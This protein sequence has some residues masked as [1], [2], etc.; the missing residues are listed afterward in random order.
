MTAFEIRAGDAADRPAIEALYPRAFPDEDLLPLVGAL[1]DRP[2]E[3][4]SLIAVKDGVLLGHIV[5]TACAVDDPAASPAL[6]GPLAV[7][8]ERQRQ[9]VGEALIRDGL[10][11]LR[12]TGTTQVLVLGDPNY[13]ARFGFEEE[14]SVAPPSETPA[15][16][17]SAW[18]SL[19]FSGAAP[20][21]GVLRP[22]EPWARPELWAP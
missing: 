2:K 1:L 20:A 5:F 7:R 16:W 14:R 15:E 6:L 13:Y 22:P 12:K 21:Q 4:L 17:K 19:T 3:A 18:R 8:P 11:R 10:S 9:G